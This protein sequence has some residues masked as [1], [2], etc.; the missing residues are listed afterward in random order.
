MPRQSDGTVHGNLRP[1]DL[2]ILRNARTD[3]LLQLLVT[4]LHL[5]NDQLGG[6]MG[7]QERLRRNAWCYAL[8]VEIQDRQRQTSL[9]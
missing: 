8:A 4:D 2:N 1:S 5:Q 3:Q 6:V 9:F 7:R